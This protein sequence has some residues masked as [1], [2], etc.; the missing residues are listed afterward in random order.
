VSQLQV[1]GPTSIT[2]G[3]GADSVTINNSIF[4]S[5]FVLGVDAGNDTVTI[6]DTAGNTIFA[7]PTTVSLGAGANLLTLAP[8]MADKVTLLRNTLFNGGGNTPMPVS[9]GLVPPPPPY[10][11]RFIGFT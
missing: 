7:G 9:P 1:V 11:V 3:F 10:T 2:S 4:N 5:T 6:Q 8:A